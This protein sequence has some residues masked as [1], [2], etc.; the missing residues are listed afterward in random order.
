M[1]QVNRDMEVLENWVPV[2]M[3]S[4][5]APNLASVFQGIFFRV[6]FEPSPR[7]IKSSSK[8]IGKRKL[9]SIFKSDK[10]MEILS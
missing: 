8:G 4:V 9:I 6:D 5:N 3:W 7:P 1:S 10:C 2:Q